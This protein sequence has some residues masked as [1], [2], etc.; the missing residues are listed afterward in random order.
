MAP[1]SFDVCVL[2]DVIEHTRD[3]MATMLRAWELLKPGGT[4]F[5]ATP[6][7][8]SWSGRLMRQ[9][10]MEFKPEHLFYFDERTVRTLLLAA[11]FTDVHVSA[12]RKTLSPDYVFAHFDRLRTEPAFAPDVEPYLQ[13]IERA[14]F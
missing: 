13:K 9:R 14:A 10:W 5:L 12:G 3:P 6:S 1:A 2:A 8:D 7:L 4:L 11:G